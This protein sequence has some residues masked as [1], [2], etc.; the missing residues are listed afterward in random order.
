MLWLILQEQ[1]LLWAKPQCFPKPDRTVTVQQNGPLVSGDVDNPLI[2]SFGYED[3]FGMIITIDQISLY[4][5]PSSDL[6]TD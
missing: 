4:F 2:Q 6:Q 5:T 1:Q 3:V